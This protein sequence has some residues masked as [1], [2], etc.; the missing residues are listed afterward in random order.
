MNFIMAGG[1]IEQ[2]NVVLSLLELVLCRPEHSKSKPTCLTFF[3]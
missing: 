3:W 2:T 1:S